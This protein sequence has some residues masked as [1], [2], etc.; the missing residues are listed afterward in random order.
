[1]MKA[2]LILL[3]GVCFLALSLTSMEAVALKKDPGVEA[4]TFKTIN[5]GPITFQVCDGTPKNCVAIV[6]Q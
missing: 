1:M 6:Q 2:K 3:S 5:Q 4:G